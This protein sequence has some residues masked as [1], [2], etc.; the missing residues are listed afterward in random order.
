M[1]AYC[2][3]FILLTNISQAEV[4]SDTMYSPE[5]T[6]P[7]QRFHGGD[8]EVAQGLKEWMTDQW[9]IDNNAFAQLRLILSQIDPR[10]LASVEGARKALWYKTKFPEIYTTN[11]F[12]VEVRRYYCGRPP[13]PTPER[14]CFK[15]V[16]LN[17]T[18]WGW[19]VRVEQ[20]NFD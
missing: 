8:A 20:R 1:K 3:L 2:L 16:Y 4:T 13:R 7:P 11:S 19:S 18:G 12:D 15:R 9:F 5:L 14:H 17:Y 6:A 10:D